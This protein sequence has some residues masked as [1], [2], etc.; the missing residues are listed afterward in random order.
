MSVTRRR[1]LVSVPVLSKAT[2]RTAASR[3][4]RAPPLMSTPLRAAAASADTIET[5]VE[6]TSAHGHEMTSSTSE[7]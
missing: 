1:P 7:R 5:G 2:Q 3:S 4:R 6:M